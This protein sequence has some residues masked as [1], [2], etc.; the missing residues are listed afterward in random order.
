MIEATDLADTTA[1]DL[2]QQHEME[3]KKELV[4][5]YNIYSFF[6]TFSRFFFVRS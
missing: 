4:F 3:E 2:L 5:S 1:D 6:F